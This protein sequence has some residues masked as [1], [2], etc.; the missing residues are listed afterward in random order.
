MPVDLFDHQ[1]DAGPANPTGPP[2][3]WEDAATI[4]VRR[5]GEWFGTKCVYNVTVDG[6]AV[7]PVGTKG[8]IVYRVRPGWH[9][10]SA[11]Q[12]WVRTE[13]LGVHLAADQRAVFV[14]GM[15]TDV[16]RLWNA[17]PGFLALT[18]GFAGVGAGLAGLFPAWEPMLSLIVIKGLCFPCLGGAAISQLLAFR[19][20]MPWRPPGTFFRLEQIGDS[21]AMPA[22][23]LEYATPNGRM[24]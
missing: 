20:M 14:V 13:T 4:E 11:G 7:A 17:A 15:Q 21:G 19:R 18:M 5:R 22:E 24:P 8:S 2:S 1:L 9:A 16:T 10:I 23:H 3:P 6:L 12:S